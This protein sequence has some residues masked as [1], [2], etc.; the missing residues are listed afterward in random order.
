ME[1]A[2]V[3]AHRVQCNAHRHRPP[4]R[5]GLPARAHAGVVRAGRA[6]GRRLHRAGPRRHARRRARVP[7]R[8]R[9]LRQH[10]RRR[11]PRVRRP[12][13]AQGD[14]R[15]V[16]EG[17]F[18]EDFTLAEL[19]TLRAR[20]R[21]PDVRPENAAFDGQFE[22]PTLQEA[23][24]LAERLGV[25]LYP[26]TKHPAYHRSLGLELEPRVT[27]AL[28]GVGVPVFFQSFEA[29]SLRELPRPR[30]QLIGGGPIDVGRD[31]GVRA[32]DRAGQAARRRR[33]RRGGARGRAGGPPLHFPGRAAL[34]PGRRARPR[35]RAPALLSRSASTASSR[36]IPTS[37]C[38]PSGPVV[39]AI[40]TCW[41]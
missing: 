21:I 19:K 7:P 14:R 10:R 1:R 30:V 36:T 25:G 12:P 9:D 33:A 24:E 13:D 18:T 40:R 5:V 29:A 31:R 15:P 38:G 41:D 20:E 11:P 2:D 32:G 37:R 34:P 35:R 8:E 22:I 17:W 39:E 27:E 4:R 16:Y 28:R 26:E 6:A 23:I 3:S